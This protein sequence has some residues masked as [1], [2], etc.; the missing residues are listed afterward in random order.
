[1]KTNVLLVLCFFFALRPLQ[2]DNGYAES[3]DGVRIYYEQSG[4]GEPLVLIGRGP[5]SS[6]TY[7]KPYFNKLE[8]I[9]SIIYFDARGRGRSTKPARS[10]SYTVD[11]DADDLENLRKHL[12]YETINV[13]GHSF[14]GIVAQ[15][16][17][18]RYPDRVKHLI[19]CNTFHSAKGWQ[20][21]IDNC[22]RR[23]QES[24]PGVWKKLYQM[25]AESK[26][27]TIAWRKL[28]DPC[29]ENLYWNSVEKKKK[30]F[31]KY[32]TIKAGADQFA[33]EVYYAMIG[34]DPDVEVGGTMKDFDLRSDLDK[35]RVPALILAGRADQIATVR[36]AAE[37][38]ELIPKA[39]LHIFDESGHYPFVEENASFTKT[40]ET[41][42]VN[43]KKRNKKTTTNLT[44][45]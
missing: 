29:I 26:S 38:Q 3:S 19:L 36:Q 41:F 1:M 2:A 22:N 37:I 23:I 33:D 5:G 30:F 31:R 16:Y 34:E 20:S 11:K 45:E 4:Q 14:G 27:N 15:S 9:F 21:N 25:R 44:Q 7:F 42:I 40:V 17:A 32:E 13:F 24:Y 10:D 35:I 18:I 43:K 28:Y 8:K 12:G 39:K 6:H